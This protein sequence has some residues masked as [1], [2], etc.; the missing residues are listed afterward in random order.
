MTKA[1]LREQ[2]MTLSDEERFELAHELLESVP[3]EL[4]PLYDWQKQAL[5]SALD[6]LEQNPDGGAPAEEAMQRVRNEVS[7]RA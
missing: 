3:T 4:Q 1:E 2:A 5:D 7:R 6:E